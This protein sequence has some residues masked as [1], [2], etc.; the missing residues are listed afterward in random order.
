[1]TS[2]G[3]TLLAKVLDLNDTQTSSLGLVFHW[4]DKAGLTLLDLKDLR[5]GAPAP[6]LATSGKADL[7]GLGGLSK[8]TAGVILR[9]LVAFE[10][11]GADVFFGEPEFD[12][13]DLL[14]TAPDGRGVVTLPR[15]ARAA[16]PAEAVLDLPHVA[17]RRPVRVLP[18]VGDVDQPKLVFFF[19]EAHLLFDRRL[20]RRSSSRSSRPCG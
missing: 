5:A 3:P 19:D 16:G 14:R 13:L 10:D 1:M 2:F 17:A 4:A 7:D 15:A 9:E 20:R 6:D 8:A 18:E 11:Q 12:T